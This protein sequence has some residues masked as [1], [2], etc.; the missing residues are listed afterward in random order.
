MTGCPVV[1][2]LDG[3][4]ID[5]VPDIHAAVGRMLEAEGFAPLSVAEVSSFVGNGVGV[6][7]EK[8]SQAV[9][10]ADA[11]RRSAMLERFRTEYEARPS[12]KTV[13]YAGVR[14]ALAALVDAGHRLGI[15]TNK[16]EA[17]SRSILGNLGLAGFFDTVVGGDS[18]AVRKPDPQPLY[19]AFAALGG[20]GLYVGD[21]EVDGETA[22]AAGVTFLLYTEGY[23]K[24][25][26]DEIAHRRAFSDFGLL[27]GLVRELAR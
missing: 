8:V 18:L 17:I 7:I 12:Y 3:T 2:D 25:G 20:E 16:P 26:L 23:R 5:S 27:P 14:E 13:T 9:G 6:L 1:F 11:E 15:C 10:V 4:L 19:A 24:S 22:A 21:S